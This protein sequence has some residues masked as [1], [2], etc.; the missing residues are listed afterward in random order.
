MAMN[1]Q[2]TFSLIKYSWA[3]GPTSSKARFTERLDSRLCLV[4]DRVQSSIYPTR[5]I[6]KIRF[7]IVLGTEDLVGNDSLCFILFAF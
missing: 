3:S 5:D 2:K 4:V 6:P 7:R 1:Q